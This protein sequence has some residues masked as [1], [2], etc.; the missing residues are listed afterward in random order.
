M[1]VGITDSNELID[2][3]IIE[4]F[5]G[6]YI[7]KYN[8]SQSIYNYRFLYY[9]KKFLGV[10][11]IL[12][13]EAQ[14]IAC[15][16]INDRK[17]LKEIIFP[18][19]DKHPLLTSKY[20]SYLQF[21]KVWNILDDK[22]LNQEEKNKAIENLLNLSLSKIYISP[23]IIHLNHKSNYEI[24]KSVVSVYW[25]IGFI[26]GQNWSNFR[27]LCEQDGCVFNPEF[28]IRIKKEENLLYLIKRLFHISNKIIFE[29]EYY[30]LKTKQ[31]R[32]LQNIINKFSRVGGSSEFQGIKSLHY[33]LWKRAFFYKNINQK[34]IAKIYQIMTKLYRK[35]NIP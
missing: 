23:A 4:K 1:I 20:F 18:I 19:F 6:N 28:S 2:S 9:I 8:I 12:K 30:L 29:E 13:Y 24:I 26:E 34:K 31:S 7:I 27:I 15:F 25:L 22:N 17:V 35:Q 3:F 16:S 11:S 21:K 5:K 33:K 32:A 10:G 14:Q